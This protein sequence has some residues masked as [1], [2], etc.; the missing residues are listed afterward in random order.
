MIIIFEGNDNIHRMSSKAIYELRVELQ[1]F[2]N[3]TR[4]ALYSN[5]TI[6]PEKDSYRLSLGTYSGDAGDYIN[7]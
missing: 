3:Q 1:G 7:E 5:F 2:L 6:G 4:H